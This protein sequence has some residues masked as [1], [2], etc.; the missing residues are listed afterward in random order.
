[1]RKVASFRLECAKDASPDVRSV[2][3][4][5]RAELGAWVESKG[6][7][8][9]SVLPQTIEFGDG[10]IADYDLEEI[11]VGTSRVHV[12]QITEPIEENA[13]FR[14]R[15][16]LCHDEVRAEVAC[17]L[18]VGVVSSRIA[19]LRFDPRCPNV[20][21]EIVRGEPD[22]TA[23]GARAS[24][25]ALSCRDSAGG[26]ELHDL[27]WDPERQ[28][29]LVVV[30]DHQGLVI[31]PALPDKL[32]RDLCGLALV[33]TTNGEASWEITRSKGREWS[34][35][36]GALRIYWPMSGGLEEPLRHPLWTSERLL[37]G[38]SDVEMAAD[39]IRAQVRKRI[40]GLSTYAH[41]EQS[42][43]G[44]L[45]EASRR[46]HLAE[47]RRNAEDGGDWRALADEYLREAEEQK[48]ALAALRMTNADLRDCKEITAC[49]VD[50]RVVRCAR[51]VGHPAGKACS[52]GAR[53]HGA[54]APGVGGD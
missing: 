16:E 4:Q 13:V 40:F 26:H 36:N 7:R 51:G 44:E 46:A 8:D 34:C 12:S 27:I 29:P 43:A 52:A 32:A 31:H 48:S 1:M 23:G 5:A 33:V 15:I 35:Y 22:W 10:R 17:D 50:R 9:A 42:L 45:R 14:T 30:S 41:S 18:S 11:D 54:I 37:T 28:V 20:I 53:A 39:R 6:R 21:H 2:F 24:T 25:R 47:L 3:D 38:V 19:P 49:T